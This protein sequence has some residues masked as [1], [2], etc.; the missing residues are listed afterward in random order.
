[1]SGLKPVAQALAEICQAIPPLGTEPVGLPQA[2]G[3]LLME[4]VVAGT[5][6]PLADMSAMDGYAVIADDTLSPAPLQ[7]VGE[8]AAGAPFTTALESGQAV[9]IFTGAYTPPNATA[10]LLQ[11]NVKEQDGYITP[12]E[13]VKAGT[14]MRNRG[15]DFARDDVLIEAGTILTARHIALA[16][17]A[18]QSRLIVKAQPKIAILSS[19]NELVSAGGIPR[20][21]QLINSNSVFLA[22]VLSQAGAD[23]TDLGVLPDEAGALAASIPDPS[24]YDLIVTTGGASVGKYDFIVTD[25]Q[26]GE[27]SGL[28]FWKIAMRP[29]KPLIFGH[30]ADTPVIGLPGNPVS[31]AVCS[32][33]FLRPVLGHMM[34]HSTLDVTTIDAI[35]THDLAEN[36]QREDYLRSIASQNEAGQWEVTAFS[37]QDSAMMHRLSRANAFLIRPAH[38]PA[39][40][41]GDTVKIALL[42]MGF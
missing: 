8:S 22:S 39:I 38:D 12:P 6:H 7:V 40:R 36:D 21:G 17:S 16:A 30:M 13:P 14:F 2:V 20:F 9:R 29:G 31:V 15:Q 23:V 42:P 41:E 24:H 34:G 5:H 10:V 32:F 18:L 37:K 33:V 11:E 27:D 4:D 3:R 28:E 26:S 25:L 35:C 1:M 19:G